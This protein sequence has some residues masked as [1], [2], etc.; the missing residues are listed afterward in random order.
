MKPRPLRYILLSPMLFT[1]ALTGCK[2]GLHAYKVSSTSMS[3]TINVGDSFLVD[4]SPAARTNLHD[5]DIVAFP[6]EEGAV[7]IKRVLAMPGERIRGEDRKVFRN[8][9]QVEEPYLAP[10]D[11]EHPISPSFSERTVPPGELF[12]LGDNRDR[13]FDSRA[14]DYA[15][16]PIS[17]VLGKYTRIYWH[18]PKP[19]R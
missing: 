7:V 11:N 13:S 4:Q 1:L 16:V 8:G 9:K 17:A 3:P 5:G 15:P 18:A 2:S 12:V 14:P 19:S 10:P 6:R